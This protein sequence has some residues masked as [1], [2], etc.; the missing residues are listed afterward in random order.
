MSHRGTSHRPSYEYDSDSDSDYERSHISS[1]SRGHK[2]SRSVHDDHHSRRDSRDRHDS[3]AS[4]RHHHGTSVVK[5]EPGESDWD[6]DYDPKDKYYLSAEDDPYGLYSQDQ[7]G[8]GESRDWDLDHVRDRNRDRSPREH[9]SHRD[10][11]RHSYHHRHDDDGH[12]DSPDRRRSKPLTSDP[13]SSR[14]SRPSAARAGSSFAVSS[15]RPRAV[16]AR[17]HNGP[18]GRP[19]AS[20]AG[21]SY[22][23][24][25]SSSKARSAR[26]KPRPV[27]TI[28]WQQA[29][30]CALEAGAVTALKV[31]NDPGGWGVKGSKIATAALGA[32]VVD[33]LVSKKMPQTKGGMRHAAMRQVAEGVIGNLVIAP[34][35]NGGDRRGGGGRRRR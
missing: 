15:S 1:P 26:A 6:T 30:R 31:R 7:K 14:P 12:R 3:P 9:S 20:R 17:S 5:R 27:A 10:P 35:T 28:P 23:H 16:R 22:L 32:A 19:R 13:K 4:S 21:S 11:A 18:A 8:E 33:T 25:G 2:S 24:G 34:I 29:V